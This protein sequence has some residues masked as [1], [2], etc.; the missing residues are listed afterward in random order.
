MTTHVFDR[1]AEFGENI[2]T[3]L[4]TETTHKYNIIMALNPHELYIFN[5]V[6]LL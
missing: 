2:L 1:H 3:P 6:D 5:E 4:V